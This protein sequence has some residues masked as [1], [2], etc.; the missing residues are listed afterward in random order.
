MLFF[1]NYGTHVRK[2]EDLARFSAINGTDVR[3]NLDNY[4]LRASSYRLIGFVFIA[5]GVDRLY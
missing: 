2:Y 3:Q 5:A 4:F 1:K